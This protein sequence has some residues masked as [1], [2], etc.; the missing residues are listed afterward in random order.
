MLGSIISRHHPTANKL[1][2]SGL[3]I[4]APN[5]ELVCAAV[6]KDIRKGIDAAI[7]ILNRFDSAL[8]R[9]DADEIYNLLQETWFGVPESTDCWRIEGF[10]ELVDLLD[11]PWEEDCE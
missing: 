7:P 6:R 4:T 9:N 2:G 11:D 10:S 8:K 5:A 1:F 3:T